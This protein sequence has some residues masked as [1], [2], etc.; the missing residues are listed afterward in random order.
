[1][2]LRYDEREIKQDDS[3]YTY[4]RLENEKGQEESGKTAAA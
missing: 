4:V 2:R 3:L 1:M